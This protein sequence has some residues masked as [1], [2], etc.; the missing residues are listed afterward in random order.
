MNT[1]II[2][3][4][5]LTTVLSVNLF[6]KAAGSMSL[7]KMHTVSYVFYVQIVTSA[8]IA[9]V[10]LVTGVLDYHPD[11]AYI[12]EKVK[13]EA[14]LWTMYSIIAMPI[15]MLGLNR[16]LGINAKLKLNAYIKSNF[17]I[18]GTIY[19]NQVILLASVGFCIL[20]LAYIFYHTDR[21]PIY[22]LLVEK[23]AE[24]AAIDR[25]SVRYNFHGID[26]IKNLLGLIMIPVMA[27]YAYVM[28]R[29]HKKI[30]Y[31]FIFLLNFLCAILVIVYDIQ[32]APVAFFI[33]G[34][35]ILEVFISKGISLKKMLIL[36]AIPITLLLVGYSFTTDKSIVDQLLNFDSAFYGRFFVVGYYGFP[37][38][39]ELFPDVITDPT[40]AVGIPNSI[41]ETIGL[42]SV[43]SARLLKE[44]V[45]TEE[46][47][48]G[49]G[50]L[51]SGYYMGEAWANYGYL[52]LVLAPFVVGFVVQTVHLF[53][54]LNNKKPYLL[55]FYTAITVKWV[56]SSGFVNFLYLK[57]LIWPFI[58]YFVSNYFIEKYL[59]NSS[60]S[61]V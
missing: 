56:V 60:S 48:K 46:V 14:W 16:L 8:L 29:I 53:L 32:K 28:M 39:L 51:F 37:L 27:Y 5:I 4:S 47:R 43:E 23:D 1:L 15:G 61:S 2:I 25:V 42:N 57:L 17:M 50:N 54:I 13:F 9:S 36:V 7:L 30:F 59:S 11:V 40:Y 44:Y 18:N 22:T 49:T 38:S 26:H 55:A 12:S 58:I 35:L 3:I 6:S 31:I 21:I 19:K 24:Q 52:G 34:F 20:V 33:T 10:L 41:L 45:H